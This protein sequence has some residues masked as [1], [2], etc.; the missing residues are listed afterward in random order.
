MPFTI[1]PHQ[2]NDPSQYIDLTLHS[3][4]PAKHPTTINFSDN[5]NWTNTEIRLKG[6]IHQ[7]LKGILKGILRAFQRA[8]T[9]YCKATFKTIYSDSMT[10][11]SIILNGI[12]ITTMHREICSIRLTITYATTLSR[13]SI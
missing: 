3:F 13:V 5:T 7:D 2:L 8:F 6:P 12:R 10:I 9:G 11:I 4:Q 1:D